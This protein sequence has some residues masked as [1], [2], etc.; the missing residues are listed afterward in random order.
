MNK[1]NLSS[2]HRK[3]TQIIAKVLIL[4]ILTT[5]VQTA[6]SGIAA[7]AWEKPSGYEKLAQSETLTL[8]G[9]METGIIAVRDNR[10]GYLWK[11]VVDNDV[12]NM[13]KVNKLWTSYMTSML[14]ISHAD[15][16]SDDGTTRKA[17]SSTDVE[18]IEVKRI[19]NGLSASF[20]FT[21]LG[22]N[23]TLVVKLENDRLVYSLP[24]DKIIQS[25]QR[26]LVSI[27]VMPFFGAADSSINGYMLYPDGSGAITRY[28]NVKQR[29]ASVKEYTWTIYSPEKVDL[30]QYMLREYNGEYNAMLPVYGIKNGSNAMLAAVCKGAEET[31]IKVAPEGASVA[32]NRIYFEF[33]YRHFYSFNLSNITVNGVSMSQRPIGTRADKDLIAEDREVMIFFLSDEKADYSGMANVYREYLLE[34]NMIKS[35]I[36]ENDSIPLG[37]DLF[38]GIKKERMIFDKFISM[39][40]FSNAVAISDEFHNNGVDSMQVMLKGWAKGGYDTSSVNWPPEKRLGGEAGLEKYA[41]YAANNNIT[42]FLQSDFN[43]ISAKS[44]KFSTD[45]DVVLHGSSIPVS[46][47]K[48]NLFFLN[49]AVVLKKV[50]SFL[51][52]SKKVGYEGI[53]MENIGALILHDYNR[54]NPSGRSQTTGKWEE[55]LE[56]AQRENKL[57]AIEGGNQYVL[58]YADRL[59]NIPLK[60][61]NYYITDEAVPFYQMVVHGLI[62]YSSVPGNLSSEFKLDKLRWVEYGCMP[63]FE[64]TYQRSVNLRNTGYNLLFTSYYKDWSEIASDVYKEFNIRLKGVWNAK[65]IKHESIA[66]NIYR[67]GYSNGTTIYINYDDEEVICDGYKVNGLDYLVV[68]KGGTLK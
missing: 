24:V 66:E 55:V 5:A 3:P 6:L 57:I 10:N 23:I 40:T 2:A 60:S 13:E 49:P 34:N 68:E 15:L 9:N 8:Y 53:A 59:Y 39:T 41:D 47:K 21:S 32:L 56:A 36:D 51:M 11:S 50:L 18:N 42:L 62:P 67:V 20:D 4:L 31:N 64:L 16:S 33:S 17:Y 45:Q 44:G 54:K 35:S 27:E 52:E 30:D 65:I 58:P 43:L 61:S 19:A 12:F 7:A 14:V 37:I 25:G 26:G 28:E 46:D 1:Q 22:F 63:Y 29:P 48:Q 38:M